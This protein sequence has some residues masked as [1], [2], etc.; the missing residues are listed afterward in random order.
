V[1]DAVRSLVYSRLYYLVT[2]CYSA[3]LM[4]RKVASTWL[5]LGTAV[6]L[7]ALFVAWFLAVG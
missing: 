5:V 1:A 2:A 4:R 7:L 6:G 3:N